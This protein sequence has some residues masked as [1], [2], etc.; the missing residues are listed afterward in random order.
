MG[1]RLMMYYL[2]GAVSAA[3]L[4]HGWLYDHLGSAVVRVK[5]VY[6]LLLLLSVYHLLI[7]EGWLR[8]FSYYDT[9][10]LVFGGA[11]EALFAYFNPKG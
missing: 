4:A 9:A 8:S 1:R 6:A 2:L 7:Y 5:L 11:V 3:L 10:T